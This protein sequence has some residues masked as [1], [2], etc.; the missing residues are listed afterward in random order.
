MPTYDYSCVPC[1]HKFEQFVPAA[2]R[3]LVN[4]PQCGNPIYEADV[5]ERTCLCFFPARFVVYGQPLAPQ[6]GTTAV[7]SRDTRT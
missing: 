6:P 3:D 2:Y 5:P 1:G 7:P 4:C